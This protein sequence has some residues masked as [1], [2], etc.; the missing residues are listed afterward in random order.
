MTIKFGMGIIK[1]RYKDNQLE[2]L[3]ENNKISLQHT[4]EVEQEQFEEFLSQNDYAVRKGK[5]GSLSFDKIFLDNQ[6]G[7]YL[8]SN[9]ISQA[10]IASKL[11]VSRAYINQLC[12][13]TNL[14]LA[15]AYPILKV[16]NLQVEDINLI[17]PPKN[18]DL[19]EF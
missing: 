18:L 5:N 13:A 16:L 3:L 11:G 9:G 10:H 4:V 8:K 19:L 6:L 7:N 14:E 12:S 17:F 1:G 2:I 15:T